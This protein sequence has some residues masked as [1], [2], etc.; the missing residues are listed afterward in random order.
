M[1][2]V[3]KRLQATFIHHPR[4]E[5]KEPKRLILRRPCSSVFA[6][7]HTRILLYAYDVEEHRHQLMQLDEFQSVAL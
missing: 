4:T 2:A 7:R 5:S 3:H 6:R 1:K